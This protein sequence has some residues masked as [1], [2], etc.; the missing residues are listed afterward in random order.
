MLLRDVG[1][2]RVPKLPFAAA[3]RMAATQRDQ[4]PKA[5]L[6]K[7][8]QKIRLRKKEIDDVKNIV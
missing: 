3:A 8:V 2:I 1:G 6:F 4:L 5:D 7:Q